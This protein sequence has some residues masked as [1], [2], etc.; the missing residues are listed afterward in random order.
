MNKFHLTA[1]TRKTCSLPIKNLLKKD[2]LKGD[3]LDYGCGKGFD[4]EYLNCDGYDIYYQPEFPTKKYDTISCNYVLNVVDEDVRIDILKK[5]K[6][7]LK[8]GGVAYVSVRRDLKEDYV[9]K[10]GTKQFLVKLDFPILTENS[11]FCTYIVK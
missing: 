2:L 7:L 1:I 10:K 6:G 9:T 5:I 11:G 3:I 4:V 8:E